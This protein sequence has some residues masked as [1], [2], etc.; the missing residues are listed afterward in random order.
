[1]G[2]IQEDGGQLAGWIRKEVEIT[3]PIQRGSSKKAVRRVQEWLNL[4]DYRIV[5]DGVFGAVSKAK[6]AQFQKNHNLQATGIVDKKTYDLLVSPL[7]SVLT[8][9]DTNHT[10]TFSGLTLAYAE[11]HLAQ[12][13]QEVGGQNK[14]PWV[15]LYMKGYEGTEYPWC[16]GFVTFVMKQ[17]AETLKMSM[18]IQGS[19]SC[20]LL[21]TQAKES[22]IFVSGSRIKNGD[23]DVSDMDGAHLFLVR[24]TSTDWTHTGFVTHF[25]EDL[26]DTIE[27]NTNDDG[28]REG[29][30]VCA[31]SRGYSRNDFILLGN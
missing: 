28:N 6:V 7:R 27:G 2:Y 19:F 24:R 30:E 29:Y 31:R 26:F 11:A 8:P 23:V 13:P 5:I 17:A 15:R 10:T 18:Q 16:A 9:I 12:H 22:G 20:D 14:G 1:M 3:D 21:A 4:H 25:E